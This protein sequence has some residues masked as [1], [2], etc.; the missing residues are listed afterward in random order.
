MDE[1]SKIWRGGGVRRL[2]ALLGSLAMFATLLALDTAPVQA[3]STTTL[4]SNS[5]Q[6]ALSVRTNVSS[7]WIATAFTTGSHTAGYTLSEVDLQ[8]GLWN[9]NAAH[10][11]A[12]IYSTTSADLPAS[13]LY[14]LTN[15]S[16]VA[17]NALNTFTAPMGA[18][19]DASTTYA[20]V[21]K[22]LGSKP[23][24]VAG[25]NSDNEEIG[26]DTGWS[27]ADN[28]V[29]SNDSGTS[30]GTDPRVLMFAVKAAEASAP[31]G[32]GVSSASVDGNTLEI[33]FD[34]NLDA[35]STPALDAFF[36]HS[37]GEDIGINGV[38]I[39][40]AT[41]TLTL[42]TAVSAAESVEVYYL[43]PSANPL[44][45]AAGDKTASFRGQAVTNN[46]GSA[47]PELTGV[48][49][50]SKPRHQG[51]DDTGKQTY[52]VD[53]PIVVEVTWDQDVTW[54]V[55]AGGAEMRVRLDVGGMTRLARLVTDGQ[56]SGTARSLWFSYTVASGDTDTDG[57]AV[58]PTAGG[59]LVVLHSG[60]TLR[61][62]ADRNAKRNHAGL[63][64]QADHKV[65]GS[66]TAVANN[67]PTYNGNEPG[68]SNTIPGTISFRE[69]PVIGEKL[70]DETTATNGFGDADGDPLRLILSA[71]RDDVLELRTLK[72]QSG[73]VFAAVRAA[74]A[75][76][77]LMPALTSP[78]T[79]VITIKATDPDGESISKEWS[80]LTT[81]SCPSFSSA[82][83][84]GKT[85]TLTLD[86]AP[87][88]ASDLFPLLQ[89]V[90][91]LLA[92]ELLAA[93]EFTVMADSAEVAAEEVAVDGSTV[94]VTL[95][96]AVAPGAVVTVSYAPGDFPAAVAFADEMV[97]NETYD[98]VPSA[99]VD[100]AD[101]TVVT[102]TFSENLVVPSEAVQYGMR[103]G[104]VV[105][106]GYWLGIP[107]RNQ[108]PNGVDI[109]GNTV[110]LTLGSPIPV[111]G[112]AT[113]SYDPR[114]A[115]NY[116]G[117]LQ[118]AAG[119]EKPAS[120]TVVATRSGS[121]PPTLVSAVVEG[122]VLALVFDQDLDS[123]SAPAGRRFWVSVKDPSSPIMGTGT[124]AV[125]GKRARVALASTPA[126]NASA[127]VFY[128]NG[129][130]ASPLRG[131]SNGPQVGDISGMLVFPAASAAPVLSSSVVADTKAVLYYGEELDPGS[132]PPTSSFTVTAG[133]NAVTVSGVAVSDSSV[134]LTLGSSVATGATATVAYTAGTNPPIQ[135]L[136][137]NDAADL[138][139][140][141]LT[142]RGTTDAGKPTLTEASVQRG[143]LTLT[144]DQE[145]DPAEVPAASAFTTSDPWWSFDRVTVRG[146]KLELG[147]NDAVT[148][149]SDRFT[150]SYAK[151]T[152][153]AL[154]NL[155][156]TAADA[157][158]GEAV[159]YGGTGTCV[160]A[161]DNSWTGSIVMRATRPFDTDFEPQP[162]WFTVTASGGPVTVT[163]AEFSPD[164]AHLLVLS[165]SREFAADETIAVSYRRPRGTPGLWNVDGNQLADV[166]DMA[167]QNRVAAVP[168]V[169][170]V[171]V[172]S[173]PGGDGVY[174]MGD[175]I[176]VA[177]V[178]SV[179]VD[180]AGVPW[181]AIDLDPA[182]GGRRP[183]SYES[184]G[185]TSEL[186][187]AHTVAEPDVSAGGIAVLAGT[188]ALA[189]GSI[190]SAATGADADLAHEGLGH[191]PA[192]RVDWAQNRAPVFGGVSQ[193]LDNAL[194]GFLVSLPM[195][196]SA[197]WDPD[198][199]PLSFELSASRG[200]VFARSAEIGLPE[201][202]V[203]VE[204]LGR[205]FFL[206]K[207]ACALAELGPPAGDAY[208][209]VITMTATD[210]DGATAQATAT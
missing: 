168:T 31:P 116:G 159:T 186:V 91:D 82:A 188:L 149:C 3:Q 181:L 192:H 118:N 81:F 10:F 54:D 72:K 202:F 169:G 193:T 98:G 59:D 37:R 42:G 15:P 138:S 205:V 114:I 105:Q 132:T 142:N 151:P 8:I 69:V 137:G 160:Y 110:T 124:A 135:D 148:P 102:L 152:A 13:Q 111:G 60:A 183:A 170:G 77:N 51:N 177:V 20:L 134:V 44:Q 94:T 32:P 190:S 166:S 154:T 117:V 206:G 74:C 90:D 131:A 200:D 173:D 9:G 45:N 53:Q 79:T 76:A 86:G 29:H 145:L 14:T 204:R 21:L 104:F 11:T 184:G 50:V 207:T 64:Q 153:A 203:H 52:P 24:T 48:A 70:L 209:T 7:H 67:A 85:L 126:A 122:A 175:V 35:S 141:T 106:G 97:T 165:V 55:S 108:S 38:G 93:G 201:G 182:A 127:T 6:T 146:S 196:R 63:G 210:P 22:S 140:Q 5:G 163:E 185:G 171:S 56:E 19:L 89:R 121:G 123:A 133:G 78:H 68:T 18:T 136:A 161:W 62:D 88:A 130:D 66:A 162:E 199:D 157:L 84:N 96:E 129:N 195:R 30:W 101:G 4:V 120:F 83:V 26:A 178:F 75:L 125:S 109:D 71:D 147:L 208:Y 49:L 150:V 180:V 57:L 33:V 2:V 39:A 194:P 156:G 176:R 65:D 103:H 46:T 17:N 189:G 113:V 99:E 143:V 23:V 198:G 164:D 167:V 158:S 191:D 197:F 172:V 16:T 61:N 34:E 95:A 100:A 174:A 1:Q 73:Y 119:G 25:T 80:L 36:V 92:D 155:W 187:F 58:S 43:Q 40:D 47:R 107:V 139:S 144:Y 27:I 87:P 41:V 28:R 112:E 128:E 12:N 115:E 179:P